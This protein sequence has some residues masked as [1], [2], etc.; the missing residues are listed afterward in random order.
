M[1]ISPE[2]HKMLTELI[3]GHQTI[4][5][6][7][8]DLEA[9]LGAN[10]S[11]RETLD[12]LIEEARARIIVKDSY[13]KEES[14]G[15]LR[16]ID[17]I[18]RENYRIEVDSSAQLLSLGLQKK[19]LDCDNASFIYLSI[20]DA[21]R[22]PIV[23]VSA[24]EHLFVRFILDGNSFNWETTIAKEL[25]DSDYINWLKISPL[26]INNGAYLR[27]LTRQETMA[28]AYYN[29]GNA[30]A[31]KGIFDKAIADYDEAIRLNPNYA[32]AHSNRGSAWFDKG[33]P[34]EAIK[35]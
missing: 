16:T 22:L 19:V 13:T 30:W 31:R 5:H 6:Q 21:L 3:S 2:Y 25:S 17:N 35:D 9:E 10:D 4:G 8:L 14:L 23:A 11:H 33:N 20:A 1:L 15:I 26:S 18:L 24:P 12:S 34:K 29:R 28:T 7:I 27:D 32:E